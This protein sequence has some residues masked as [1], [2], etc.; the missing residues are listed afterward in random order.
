MPTWKQA[1]DFACKELKFVD[2]E[3]Y[4]FEVYDIF[5]YAF[6]FNKLDFILRRNEVMPTEI[7]QKLQNIIQ[8][9]KNRIPLQYILGQWEFMG[10]NFKVGEG[11]LIPREDTSVL[12]DKCA[13]YLSEKN[14]PKIIDLCSGSGC[15]PIALEKFLSN[16]PEIY[17]VEIS[18]EAFSY[19]Q[20]N[21][22]MHNSG[23]NCI[24]DDIFKVHSKFS[25][26]FFDA[27]ISN[28]PYIAKN[29]LEFLSPEVQTEPI[30]ALNGGEDGLDF[31]KGICEHWVP[32][33]KHGGFLGFEIGFNQSVAV[34]KIAG[35][36]NLELVCV[37][38]D[39]NNIDRVVIL[40]KS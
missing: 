20:K 15:I 28:P 16:D 14:N 4:E 25:D 8:K 9:R 38:K 24:N 35:Q 23:V 36:Y 40:K 37:T 21:M 11:V 2:F 29:E 17:A 1:Y 10:L 6:D 7:F 26:S 12:V 3:D 39:I 33:I 34:K 18:K 13:Q 22:E 19:M 27:V 31:Y 32:K 5:K 30:I